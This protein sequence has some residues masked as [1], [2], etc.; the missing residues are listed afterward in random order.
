A[1]AACTSAIPDA[2]SVHSS[3]ASPSQTSIAAES[4]ITVATS[5]TN[6]ST[7]FG[8]KARPS[9]F[10]ACASTFRV[11]QAATSANTTITTPA[12]TMDGHSTRNSGGDNAPEITASCTTVLTFDTTPA[13]AQ[14][15]ASF[16][17][18]FAR[19]P[20]LAIV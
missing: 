7:C 10:S 20:M 19:V 4:T 3:A 11:V 5:A 1:V 18:C 9:S 14:A 2:A 17:F 15:M 8:S 6:T 12:A 13:P 16:G